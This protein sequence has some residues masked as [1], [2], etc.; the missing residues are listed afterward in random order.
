MEKFEFGIYDDKKPKKIARQNLIIRLCVF[1]LFILSVIITAAC[2]FQE[3]EYVAYGSYSFKSSNYYNSDGR[4]CYNIVFGNLK[5]D[6]IVEIVKAE[7]FSFKIDGKII[8][9]KY[10]GDNE[11][12]INKTYYKL[13]HNGNNQSV[14]VTFNYS[15]DYN[16]AKQVF[17]KGTELNHVNKYQDQSSTFWGL[18]AVELLGFGMIL[19]TVNIILRKRGYKN[20]NKLY[21]NL[22]K[23]LHLELKNHAFE[24]TKIF[25]FQQAL[26]CTKVEEQLQILVDRNNKKIALVNYNTRICAIIDYKDIVNYKIIEKDG[27]DEETTTTLGLFYNTSSSPVC[28]KLAFVIVV[29][30]EE[31]PQFTY[32]II[33]GSV[34]IT[35]NRYKNNLKSIT[36]ISSFLDVIKNKSPKAIDFVHC[37]YCGTKNDYNVKKC[38]SCG[39]NLD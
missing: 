20:K 2:V 7:D 1:A 19:I 38:I 31:E 26:S 6:G 16:Y 15:Y 3:K 33:N 11:S 21:Y 25:S 12:S 39:S 29:N 35:S 14:Y 27:A 5:D 36:E 32:E 24:I 28:K 23:Q 4:Y 9:G 18:F 17:Y 37:K 30:D 22:N 10:I 8:Y 34:S 13:V